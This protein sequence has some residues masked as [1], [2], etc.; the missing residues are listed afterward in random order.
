MTEQRHIA[1]IL[2]TLDDAIQKTELLIAKLKQIKQ[3]LLH[4][5]LTR[6][7]DENGQLRDPIAHPEQFKDSPLGRIPKEWEQKTLE[8][9]ARSITSGS[10]GWARY[11]SESGA[12]FLRIG[13]LTREHINLRCE[14]QV[15][16]H[17]PEEGEGKRTAVEEGDLL[18]SITADLGIIGV[19]PPNLGEAYVNQHLSL[20]RLNHD[21]VNPRWVG[22]WLAGEVG[23]KQFDRLNDQGAKSGLNLPT[24][25]LL[26]VPVPGKIEQD[27]IANRI[28]R[29]DNVILKEKEFLR[30]LVLIKKGLMHD[31][32]TGKVRVQTHKEQR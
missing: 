11:Y 17:V 2:D 13:N 5:L 1:E 12:L 32:L 6:G 26:I 25:G 7:I 29:H 21:L 16:V 27:L 4:D 20:V 19:I 15:F 10:R 8:Q 9:L 22:H 3:G 18:I 23:Q 28:D 31:L 24:I 30:E 14:S